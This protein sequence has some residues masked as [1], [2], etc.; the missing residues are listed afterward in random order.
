M[1]HELK[2]EFKDTKVLL[3]FIKSSYNNGYLT[4]KSKKL[5]FEK[6]STTY[7]LCKGLTN[8]PVRLWNDEIIDGTIRFIIE[9]E[10]EVI[11]LYPCSI[12]YEEDNN[13]YSFII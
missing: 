1:K 8:L 5:I 10:E 6:N 11:S 9:E 12:C 2:I 7:N 3:D 4:D 13:K